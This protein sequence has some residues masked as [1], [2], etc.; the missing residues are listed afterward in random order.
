[1]TLPAQFHDKLTLV[2]E[3]ISAVP[4][5][6]NAEYIIVFTQKHAVGAHEHIVTPVF[7][8]IAVLGKNGDGGKTS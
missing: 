5:V 7:D 4:F 2:I 1:V 8:R 3:F 6:V